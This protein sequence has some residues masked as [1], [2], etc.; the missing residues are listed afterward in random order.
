MPTIRVDQFQG[1]AP[2][3][4]RRQIPVG[5]AQLAVNLRYDSGDLRPLRAD[6]DA[7]EPNLP[8]DIGTLFHYD[9]GGNNRRFIGF[10]R[11]HLV[12]GARSPVPNDQ[13]N[14]WY[15]LVAGEGLRAI[16][17]TD[18]AQPFPNG[19]PPVGSSSGAAFRPFGGYVVGLPATSNRP[20][21]ETEASSLAEI[22]F[23]TGTAITTI[24][25]TRPVTVNLASEPPFKSGQRVRF[26]V[27]PVYPR[28]GD[29]DGGMGPPPEDPGSPD[30]NNGQVW[31]LDGLEGVVSN[32]GPTSFD[33]TGINTG[34]FADFTGPDLA[35]LTIRRVLTDQELESRAYVWTYVNDFDEEGPP[36]PASAV[37]DV[38]DGGTALVT[39]AD[40]AENQNAAG[41]RARVNRIRLY[42]TVAGQTSLFVLVGTLNFQGGSSPDSGLEWINAPSAANPQQPFTAKIRDAVPAVELGEPLPSEGWLP[43]PTGLRGMVMLPNGIMAGWQ[44]NTLYFSEPYLPHAWDPD[45]T[46]TLTDEVIGAES[47]GNTLVVGTNGRPYIVSGVDPSS[48]RSQKLPDHAPLLHPQAIA[49]AGTGVIYAADTGL[50]WVSQGGARV[51]TRKWDK[52]T[53]LEVAQGRRKLTWFDSYA[54]LYDENRPPYIFSMVGDEAEA[55]ALDGTSAIS[56]AARRRNSLVVVKPLGPTYNILRTFNENQDGP[57]GSANKSQAGWRSGLVTFRR[58]VNVAVAQVLAERYPLVLTVYTLRP[59]SYNENPVGQPDEQDFDAAIYNVVGPEPFRL[60]SGQLSRDYSVQIVTLGRVQ[61]VVVSTSMDELRSQ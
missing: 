41:T 49:D 36:S 8:G 59:E 45:N 52:E 9:R 57:G 31:S 37:V 38:E 55:S 60:K 6:G 12:Y 47:F 17:L 19:S 46:L 11:N 53:W 7:G 16:N 30:P 3:F 5:A 24:S 34:G 20:F 15:W 13:F 4:N 40:L 18:P 48:M 27:N 29:D 14:R 1:L 25:T 10:G 32:I 23:G 21:A 54:L 51:L 43:P 33:V 50:V 28:P 56:A 2:R 44:G 42:R 61:S 26:V 39:I 35:N 22:G 58:P